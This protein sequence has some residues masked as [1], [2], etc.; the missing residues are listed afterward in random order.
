MFAQ[1]IPL[2]QPFFEP[3]IRQRGVRMVEPSLVQQHPDSVLVE[4]FISDEGEE[5]CFQCGFFVAF[6]SLVPHAIGKFCLSC[7]ISLAALK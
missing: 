1:N 7:M 5:S 3:T 2:K 6:V 4:L